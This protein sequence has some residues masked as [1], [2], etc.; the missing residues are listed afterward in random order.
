ML[1]AQFG[2]KIK[3][4]VPGIRPPWFEAGDQKRVTTPREAV[5]SGADYLVIG[6]PIT[7]HRSPREALAKILNEL[8]S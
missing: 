5:E 6:R 4:V 7:T 1:R 8:N 2:A 3:L